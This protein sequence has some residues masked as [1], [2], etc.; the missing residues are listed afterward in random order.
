MGNRT[1]NIELKALYLKKFNSKGCVFM[2][3]MAETMCL[4]LRMTLNSQKA[5]KRY[6]KLEMGVGW[7]GVGVERHQRK[8]SSFSNVFWGYQTPFCIFSSSSE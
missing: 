7:D 4:F 8:I 6:Q 2:M 1:K 3:E 5:V